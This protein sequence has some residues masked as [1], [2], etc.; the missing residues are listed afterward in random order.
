MP[1]R[2][3]DGQPRRLIAGL[4]L[5]TA[6][7]LTFSTTG[8]AMATSPQTTS[9]TV[10]QNAAAVTAPQTLA[11]DLDGAHLKAAE[12]N[13][14]VFRATAAGG[15]ARSVERKKLAARALKVA[16]AARAHGWRLPIKNYVLTSG[17]GYR[18]G[19]LHAGED[20]GAPTG[21]NL[22][23]MSTGTVDF[24]G[25]ESGYGNVLKICYWDGT[26][27]YFAHMSSISVSLGEAVGPGQVVGQSGN[28]GDS[29]GPHLHLEIHPNG[30]TAVDPL[31]W[32]AD[33]NIAP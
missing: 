10:S 12:Q 2:S 25:Q 23:S 15:V 8:A 5:P 18:W 19:R 1:V 9:V 17:F 32:L 13:L 20:F 16:H 14:A 7:A 6:V 31:P 33:H 4:V 22:S 27:S 28:T 26:I 30:G 21:T 29:T 24:A 11:F 3:P